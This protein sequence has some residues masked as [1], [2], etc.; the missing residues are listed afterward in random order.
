ARARAPRKRKKPRSRGFR[1]RTATSGAEDPQREA[2]AHGLRPVLH[3]QLPQD[4]LH[5]VLHRERADLEDRADLDV[6]LAEVD[7]LEDLLLA[8]R[9]QP[10][11][12]LLRGRAL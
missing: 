5:V 6:A 7:P 3:V 9:Q 12:A 10:D 8:H 4:L 2:L 1:R 11:A